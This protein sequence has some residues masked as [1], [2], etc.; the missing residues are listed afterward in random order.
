MIPSSRINII[1]S[2]ADLSACLISGHGTV[3]DPSTLISEC[4]HQL[5]ISDIDSGVVQIVQQDISGLQTGGGWKN[6][7]SGT[8]Q[9]VTHIT[10][11]GGT[12]G[13]GTG[14]GVAVEH[15][16]AAV[17]IR[18]VPGDLAIAVGVIPCNGN[19]LINGLLSDFSVCHRSA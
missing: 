10:G 1:G 8:L 14:T 17:I 3:A 7:P 18:T 13:V 16:R 9:T 4:F 19:G 2:Y 12:I 15:Q 11:V 6:L 5:T